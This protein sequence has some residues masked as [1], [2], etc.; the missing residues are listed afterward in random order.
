[1]VGFAAL[2]IGAAAGF[3]LAHWLRLPSIP[4]L[5]LAGLL[6]SAAGLV[7]SQ[8]VLADSLLLGLTVLV[9]VAGVELNPRRVGSQRRAA[10]RVGTAQF[11]VLLLLGLVTALAL[12]F[13]LAEAFYLALALTAS[14]T[15]VV[16]RILQ[17][18]KQL[19]EPFGRL[20]IGVLLLQDVLVILLIPVLTRA[21]QGAVA[22]ALGLLAALAMLALAWVCL[23]WVTPFLI[24]RLNLDE[25]ALLLVTLA[26]LFVYL[27]LANLLGLPLVAGAFLAGVALSPF[28]VSGILRGQLNSLSDFFLAV[29]FTALGGLLVIPSAGDLGRA[30]LLALL[31]VIATPPLVTVVAERSGLSARPAIESGLLLAQTSE[32]SLVVALQ[33]LAMGHVDQGIF[34]IVALTT[35]GTMIL[36]PFLATDRITWRLMALHPLRHRDNVPRE[37][38][39]HVLLLGC[40]DNGMPLL[41]TLLGSGHE[42]LVV[43]DDPAVI[44]RLREGDVPCI[45]GDGSDDQVLQAANARRAAVIVSTMRRPADNGTLLDYVAGV[46]VLVRVFDPE[47][48]EMIRSKGGTPILYSQAAAEDFFRWLDQAQLVGGVANER[49]QRPRS[50]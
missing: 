49:R 11:V 47:D 26:V 32:F 46:P 22:A 16:I 28:P 8:E 41:E 4:M 43:D 15:L 38:E 1:M 17:Q 50:A 35:V 20:V 48:A 33:G 21:P 45:R 9:F 42:V 10:L 19:F 6:L 29:F 40:G 44:E 12:G 37:L 30:V 13:A 25:E 2:L 14:S 39:D 36:T 7:P 27:A 24:T 3:G 5:L 34:T 23:R 18:R 31:V